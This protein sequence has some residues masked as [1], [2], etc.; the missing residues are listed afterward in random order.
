M[1]YNLQ[2]ISLLNDLIERRRKLGNIGALSFLIDY[3]SNKKNPESE[4]LSY[5]FKEFILSDSLIEY[6]DVESFKSKDKSGDI[7]KSD[8]LLKASKIAKVSG[9]K[10]SFDF[11]KSYVN[12]DYYPELNLLMANDADNDKEWLECVNSYLSCQSLSCIELS[13][14][15]GSRFYRLFSEP[16]RYIH[17]GPK[18][19]II[20]PVFNAEKTLEFAAISILKQSWRNIELL[21]VDDASTDNSYEI[22]KSLAAYDDRI[23]IFR[24]VV[25]VGP[26]VSKNKALLHTSGDF[27][28]GH[29]ADDWAH[30]ERIERQVSYLVKYKQSVGVCFMLRMLETGE[31]TFFSKRNAFSPDGILRR[32]SISCIFE[33]KFLFKKL[34]FWDCVRFGADSE[35]LA[36]VEIALGHEIFKMPFCSMF[37]LDLD[38]SLTNNPVYGIDKVNGISEPRLLYKNSWLSWH[39]TL[40]KDDCFLGLGGGRKSFDV[41]EEGIIP[42]CDLFNVLNS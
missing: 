24:N 3:F 22:M 5:L 27:I 4:S 33:R 41:P 18:V 16:R 9:F 10:K 32:A 14:G 23:K 17:V 38:T 30:P 25:N 8:V 31:I 21:L 29:D 35:M 15:E 34:G 37:C 36:R 40:N 1:D 19:S 28:T 26:Y 7:Y 11:A 20:M 12:P 39:K 6:N 42:D 2:Y 13:K